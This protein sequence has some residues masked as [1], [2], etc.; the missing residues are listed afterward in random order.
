MGTKIKQLRKAAPAKRALQEFSAEL[1]VQRTA[2]FA[3]A[4]DAVDS[5]RYRSLLLDALQWIET[6]SE[7]DADTTR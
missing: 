5:P 7:F 6:V 4:K 3:K 1:A 2:A